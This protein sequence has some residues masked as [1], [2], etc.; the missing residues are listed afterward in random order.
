MGNGSFT[1]TNHPP[2]NHKPSPSTFALSGLHN[3]N[4]QSRNS[5]QSSDV[6]GLPFAL[7]FPLNI[8]N[9]KVRL[10]CEFDKKRRGTKEIHSASQLLEQKSRP[11]ETFSI[12]T[13]DIYMNVL[14]NLGSKESY[15]SHAKPARDWNSKPSKDLSISLR[16]R[17][18]RLSSN[19][20]WS[21]EVKVYPT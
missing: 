11:T 1:T 14:M 8:H 18:I 4:N 13:M 19:N 2:T 16:G 10:R 7:L 5:S 3:I 12:V 6:N 15:P 17:T 9:E 20:Y 21:S